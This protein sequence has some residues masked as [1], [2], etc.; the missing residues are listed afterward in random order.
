MPQTH[1][2]M[3]PYLPH[4]TR[5]TGPLGRLWQ[6]QWSRR[7]P[8]LPRLRALAQL[9]LTYLLTEGPEG[10]L[11]L[12]DQHAAHERITYERLLAQHDAGVVQSQ[13][14]LLPQQV[15]LPPGAQQT[16]LAAADEL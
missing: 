15:D 2:V 10:A 5:W 4:P 12:I 9:G 11:Y 6:T 3:P 14:L 8:W 16:L 13:A 7:A 1:H